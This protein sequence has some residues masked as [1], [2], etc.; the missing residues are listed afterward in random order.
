MG[1]AARPQHFIEHVLR[2]GYGKPSSLPRLRGEEAP[3]RV[4][5]QRTAREVCEPCWLTV[6][7][8]VGD[9]VL[10]GGEWSPSG[11]YVLSADLAS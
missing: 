3:E 4:E 9:V 10:T 6:S 11:A 1:S 7:R 8:E 5:M 2:L